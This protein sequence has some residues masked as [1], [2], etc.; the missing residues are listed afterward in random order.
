MEGDVVLFAFIVLLAL[1]FFLDHQ[2]KM[3]MLAK[4]WHPD[5]FQKPEHNDHLLAALIFCLVGI[6]FLIS[7]FVLNASGLIIVATILIA[8]GLAL[9]LDYRI[10]RK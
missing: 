1:I 8:I 9:L 3:M 7:M 6:A 2:K 10:R 5:K 4:G